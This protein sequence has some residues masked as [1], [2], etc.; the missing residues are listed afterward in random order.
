MDPILRIIK[1]ENKKKLRIICH[2]IKFDIL[3]GFKNFKDL[4]RWYVDIS[5]REA[6]IKGYQFMNKKDLPPQP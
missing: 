5:K 4:S 6:V 3:N 1:T 2:V